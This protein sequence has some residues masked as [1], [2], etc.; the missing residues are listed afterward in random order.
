MYG[1]WWA[2]SLYGAAKTIGCHPTHI[3]NHKD[4]NSFKGWTI[5]ETDQDFSDIPTKYVNATN[6]FVKHFHMKTMMNLEAANA[7]DL[8]EYDEVKINILRMSR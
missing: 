5:E 2:T 4:R 8:P 1:I 6:E 7:D 3:Y